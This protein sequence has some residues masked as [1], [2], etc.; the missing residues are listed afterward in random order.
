VLEQQMAHP[1]FFVLTGRQPSTPAMLSPVTKLEI[2]A[3]VLCGIAA[4]VWVAAAVSAIAFRHQVA[5]NAS[6]AASQVTYV[7]LPR[8]VVIGQRYVAGQADQGS[9]RMARGDGSAP[10]PSFAN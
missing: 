2:A 10:Q 9:I 4:L 5:L 7:E 1:D 3:T 6:A 8:V